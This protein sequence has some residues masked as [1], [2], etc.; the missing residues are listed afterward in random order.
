MQRHILVVDDNVDVRT[1]LSRRLSQNGFRVSTAADGAAGLEAV[2]RHTPCCVLLD[3]MMPVMDGFAFLA[4]L[5]A[6][7]APPPVFV[8]THS[9][10]PGARRR[11][12]QLGAGRV[13]TKSEA[14]E[15]SF[16]TMLT[17]LLHAAPP[18]AAA[19]AG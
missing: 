8:V 11:A 19:M 1:I 15:R 9:D 10:D 17:E 2:R 16:G 18:P 6:H 13:F 14:F 4:A 12:Q 3:L 7:P 5:Q